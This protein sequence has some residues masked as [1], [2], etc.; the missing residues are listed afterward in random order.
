MCKQF[1]FS[2]FAGIVAL[3]VVA[4]CDDSKPN[5][6]ADK[7]PADQQS[8]EPQPEEQAQNNQPDDESEQKAADETE[9]VSVPEEG[10]KFDPSAEASRI[11]DGAWH[12]N[13]NDKVH[14]A[15]MKKGD[16]ECPVCGMKLK[17][18]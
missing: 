10:K 18:K 14:Y 11:P 8:A 7:S 16:G 4:G 12:C 17:Q 3:A 2:F 6:T 15:A 1:H 9:L 5:S 13:M